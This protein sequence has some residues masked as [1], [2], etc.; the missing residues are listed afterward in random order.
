[1]NRRKFLKYISAPGAVGLAGCGGSSSDGNATSTVPKEIEDA[2]DEHSESQASQ[3]TATPEP[4]AEPLD[5]ISTGGNG[6]NNRYIPSCEFSSEEYT[7]NWVSRVGESEDGAEEVITGGS[8]IYVLKRNIIAAYHGNGDVIWTGQNPAIDNLGYADD[9]IAA[10]TNNGGILIVNADT[11]ERESLLT[12]VGEDPVATQ[13]TAEGYYAVTYDDYGDTK[14]T[15]VDMAAGEVVIDQD[16]EDLSNYTEHLL[17]AGEQIFLIGYDTTD[18]S[19]DYP[20]RVAA[21]NAADGELDFGFTTTWLTDN[22]MEGFEGQTMVDDQL[23]VLIAAYDNS[24]LGT[25]EKSGLGLLAFDSDGTLNWTVPDILPQ[26]EA[27]DIFTNGSQ[28]CV[29]A[30]DTTI[31]YSVDDGSKTWEYSTRQ[32]FAPDAG[33]IADEHLLIPDQGGIEGIRVHNIETDSGEASRTQLY[34]VPDDRQPNLVDAPVHIRPAT[35]GL[36]TMGLQLRHLSTDSD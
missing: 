25:T 24:T 32:S 30:D 8:R 34:T 27:T 9:R 20:M 10:T 21:W 12:D 15:V 18:D 2:R 6:Q 26:P 36:Y 31:A 14:L 7:S 33:I 5:W 13:T 17:A 29:V 23:F 3:D 4:D 11:G 1:M 28:V 19:Q 35:S 22:S 16:L